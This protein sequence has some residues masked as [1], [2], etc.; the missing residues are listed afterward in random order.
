MQTGIGVR[1][2]LSV[3]GG[4]YPTKDGTCVRDYIHVLDLAK[5]HVV[6]MERLLDNKN[7]ANFE[8]FNVGTGKGSTVL[9]VIESFE[10]V[11]NTVVKL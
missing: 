8:T 3:F 2:E 9:E 4:D 11:S 1:E 6:A 7:S 10:R 5:A